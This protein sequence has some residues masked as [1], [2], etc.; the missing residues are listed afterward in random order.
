MTAQTCRAS[1]SVKKFDNSIVGF[2]VM[3]D[4]FIPS[5]VLA[6]AGDLKGTGRYRWSIQTISAL[7]NSVPGINEITA[8][9]FSVQRNFSPLLNLDL[10]KTH[11]EDEK[12]DAA[13]EIAR[14]YWKIYHQ[15]SMGPHRLI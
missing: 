14:A 1:E 13:F 8:E 9:T 7:Q 12:R 3:E 5:L 15:D 10:G 2:P 6:R 11:A 4:D